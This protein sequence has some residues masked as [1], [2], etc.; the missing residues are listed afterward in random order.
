MTEEF[1]NMYIDKIVNEISELTKVKL[2]L[3]TQLAY[4]EKQTQEAVD[5]QNKLQQSNNELL[6]KIAQSVKN[7]RTSELEKAI[8]DIK[9]E[10]ATIQL[11]CNNLRIL[12][13]KIIDENSALKVEIGE[14]RSRKKRVSNN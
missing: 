7:D 5:L 3:Q 10:R 1:I 4:A 9:N 6:E 2:L 11:E 12:H 13:G 14:L 8:E